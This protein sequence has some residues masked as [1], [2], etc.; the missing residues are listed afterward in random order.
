MDSRSVV[1]PGSDD[2]EPVQ[3]PNQPACKPARTAVQD[4]FAARLLAQKMVAQFIE[5][6]RAEVRQMTKNTNRDFSL[7]L[8]GGGDYCFVL[9]VWC[10]ENS[11][12]AHIRLQ[13]A[14]AIESSWLVQARRDT[15]DA[16]LDR[17][18]LLVVQRFAAVEVAIRLWSK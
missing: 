1:A 12:E 4:V 13:E 2:D 7:S 17:L 10:F 18:I 9:S 8:A 6:H 5:T 16:A 14:T 11:T 15:A 3:E